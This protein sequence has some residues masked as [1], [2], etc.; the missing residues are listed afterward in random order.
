MSLSV[1]KQVMT[2]EVFEQVQSW[3]TDD[4]SFVEFIL[5]YFFLY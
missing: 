4:K 1:D 3:G 2:G 5:S